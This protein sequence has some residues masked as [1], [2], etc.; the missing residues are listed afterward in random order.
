MRDRDLRRSNL[1]LGWSKPQ[2]HNTPETRMRA[3]TH[4]TAWAGGVEGYFVSRE[5]RDCCARLN[6]VFSPLACR[7]TLF[8]VYIYRG[9]VTSGSAVK[10]GPS[11]GFVI[12]P[13]WSANHVQF[14]ALPA[15]HESIFVRNLDG[16]AAP[17]EKT[18]TR[19]RAP[20]RARAPP[21]RLGR[22]PGLAG[23]SPA[24]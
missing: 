18:E 2:G 3:H 4:K 20:R 12:I 14:R 10:H 17:R 6:A 15:F 21:L 24:R 16:N 9:G 7:R 5:K 23:L 13:A 19:R 8:F 1:A 11:L 22:L